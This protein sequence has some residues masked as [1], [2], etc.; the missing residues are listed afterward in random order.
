M[1]GPP[2]KFNPNPFEYHRELELSID[3]ITNLGLGVGRHDGW[4]IMVPQVAIGERIRCRI[5]R[6]HSNYSEADLVEV[7]EPSTERAVPKCPLFGICGGCQ[8]QHLVYE[9]QLKLKQQQVKELL[10][11]LAGIDVLVAPTFSTDQIYYY[12][13]KL[14]PHFEKDAENIGFLKIGSR[15]AIVDVEHCC[16]ATSAI[17]DKLKILRQEICQ[18]TFR[19]GGTL[20]LRDTEDGVETDSTKI[21]TQRIGFWNFQVRA[22][23]FFQ[24]NPY[25]LPHFVDYIIR[26]SSDDGVEFLLDM[27]CGVGVFGI[28]GSRYFKAV[29]GIE[30][31]ERAIQLAQ[32]NAANNRVN[33]IQFVA[34]SSENIFAQTL[35]EAGKTTVVLDPP[36]KGCDNSFLQQLAIFGPKKI[37]YVSCSPD[38]Q[39]RDVKFLLQHHYVVRRVQ[40]FD[41]FPQTRHIEN[42]ITLL[43]CK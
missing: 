40:P 28:C 18:K 6:N 33:N 7:L 16:I 31:N 38:T 20:L 13:S 27:Y 3:N 34:G 21:I 35:P 36:R 37:V 1:H 41:L 14:T 10:Q 11:K 24:N 29:T 26:E 42:V 39:A 32:Q 5:Y 22:G 4:V 23:E 12:R 2:R 9:T 25:I 15:F 43:A 19:F 8:Y 30:I 17:N